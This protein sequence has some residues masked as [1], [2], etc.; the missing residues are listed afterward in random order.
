MKG[1]G[2]TALFGSAMA[3]GLAVPAATNAKGMGHTSMSMAYDLNEEFNRIGSGDSKW[4]GMCA[5]VPR[6]HDVPLSNGRC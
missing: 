4:D 3:G 6:P 2:A 5:A 1:A